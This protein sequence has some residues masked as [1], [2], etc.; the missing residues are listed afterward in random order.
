[1]ADINKPG[2]KV[3]E[4]LLGVLGTI[5]SVMGPLMTG[6]NIDLGLPFKLGSTYL[7]ENRREKNLQNVLKKAFDSNPYTEGMAE[8]AMALTQAGG[9]PGLLQQLSQPPSI[10]QSPVQPPQAMPGMSLGVEGIPPQAP[11]D[12]LGSTISPQ[13]IPNQPQQEPMDVSS[14]EFLQLL[15]EYR[16]DIAEQALLSRASAKPQN[17]LNDI[18]KILAVQSYETP[19]MKRLADIEQT[20]VKSDI[21]ESRQGR[22]AELNKELEK[23]AGREKWTASETKLL[24][25]SDVAIN[26]S[27]FL[28]D[29]MNSGI[30][31]N[32][33]T[34]LAG[35]SPV[36]ARIAMALDP[37]LQDELQLYRDTLKNV[38]S[39]VKTQSGVQYGFRELQW[40]KSSQPSEWDTPEMFR[41][42]V[43][44][45]L[46]T[47]LWNKYGVIIRKAERA[48][49]AEVALR[50]GMTPEQIKAWK[51]LDKQLSS[52]A[53]SAKSEATIFSDPNNAALLQTLGM[54]Q[55]IPSKGKK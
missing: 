31:H 20:K 28:I 49:N 23:Q 43:S 34:A 48:E 39:A 17:E 4:T 27:R 13:V 21:I 3:T 18:L 38:M 45:A 41:N 37:A 30:N 26:N 52:R 15:A 53:T 47:Q 51:I 55:L 11:Q 40:I 32:V 50:E 33:L 46:N 54:V 22:T 6:Q 10:G 14:P 42:G 1:M 35:K 24:Q 36:S 2:G 19:Q 8:D 16:P 9:L 5:G 25:D 12:A 29:R 44:M 7:A